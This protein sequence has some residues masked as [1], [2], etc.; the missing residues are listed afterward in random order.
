MVNPTYRQ[1]LEEVADN[2]RVQIP[3][4]VRYPI[5][6]PYQKL[7]IQIVREIDSYHSAS[8][9]DKLKRSLELS[10]SLLN[11]MAE[12]IVRSRLESDHERRVLKSKLSSLVAIKK[13][14]GVTDENL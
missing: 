1:L 5:K 9:A 10:L 13:G 4:N 3:D 7:F 12:D 8:D 14:G 6:S 2:D 11:Q